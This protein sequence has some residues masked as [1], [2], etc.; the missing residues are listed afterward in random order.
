MTT[1]G[2]VIG[3]KLY[4]NILS[5]DPKHTTVAVWIF[6]VVC[7]VPVGVF[8][9]ANRYSVVVVVGVVGVGS[10]VAVGVMV[11]LVGVGDTVAVVVR[12]QIIRDAVFVVV[13]VEMV[14]N[15]V[16]VGVLQSLEILTADRWLDSAGALLAFQ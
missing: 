1:G 12:V 10:A 3:F 13:R 11:L 15:P 5:S 14:R 6:V 4:L 9:L 8:V 2:G 16:S 7:C